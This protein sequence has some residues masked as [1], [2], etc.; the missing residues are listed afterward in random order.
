[1]QGFGGQPG[2]ANGNIYPLGSQFGHT[3]IYA[4]VESGQPR[5]MN[6]ETGEYYPPG[7]IPTIQD[8]NTWEQW[9]PGDSWRETMELANA[10]F[11]EG[12]RQAQETI[13]RPGEE[14]AANTAQQFLKDL[15]GAA[16]KWSGQAAQNFYGK[17]NQTLKDIQSR[18]QQT[19]RQIINQAP[20]AAQQAVRQAPQIAQRTGQAV[21][22]G[23]N[24]VSGQT[25]R[26]FS[27]GGSASAP[28]TTTDRS[29]LTS[30]AGDRQIFTGARR[31]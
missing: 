5:I 3:T 21:T 13:L 2:G 11:A 15:S 30:V 7:Y 20:Q 6:P 27:G 14:A 4:V 9:R 19:G 12:M 8:P 22:Q 26:F 1:M 25:A 29:A 17:D 16:N 23:A 24:Q 28:Y 31:N 18:A 10:E